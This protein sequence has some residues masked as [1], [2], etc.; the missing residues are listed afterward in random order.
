MG[1]EASGSKVA[2]E[3]AKAGRDARSEEEVAPGVSGA[4]E[5]ASPEA[6]MRTMFWG[7]H[8]ATDSWPAGASAESRLAPSQHSV[9]TPS[10]SCDPACATP[11]ALDSEVPSSVEQ[12]KSIVSELSA[13]GLPSLASLP[14]D[15]APWPGVRAPPPGSSSDSRPSASQREGTGSDIA[16][17]PSLGKDESSPFSSALTQQQVRAAAQHEYVRSSGTRGSISP[18]PSSRRSGDS[19]GLSLSSA[20]HPGTRNASLELRGSFTHGSSGSWAADWSQPVPGW[21]PDSGSALS[22][23]S[24]VASGSYFP[25]S[26]QPSGAAGPSG[27]RAGP[28]QTSPFKPPMPP[29]T[30][31]GAWRRN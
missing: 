27:S 12:Y 2:G 20:A 14:S 15:P 30:R 7:S 21:G 16:S 9:S 23:K 26:P 11:A 13:S 31:Y 1:S 8:P 29:P 28:E 19:A 22:R 24:S 18:I 10:L 25:H 17:L 3:A 4:A 5:S 6:S